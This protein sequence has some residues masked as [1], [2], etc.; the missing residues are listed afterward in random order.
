MTALSQTYIKMEFTYDQSI[1][2][3]R[4]RLLQPRAIYRTELSFN[5]ITVQRSTAPHYT[6]VSYTW[7]TE[8]P[9]ETIQLNGRKFYVRPNLWSCLHYIGQAARHEPWNYLWVDAICINQ[10]DTKERNEQVKL[11]D[12]TYSNAASV[13]VWLGLTPVPEGVVISEW[14]EKSSIKTLEVDGLFW[15]DYM[16]D[17]ANREYWGRYWI[18]QEFL[19]AKHLRIY[20]SDMAMDWQAFKDLVHPPWENRRLRTYWASPLVDGRHPN[21]HPEMSQPLSQLLGQHRKSQCKD[22]RDRVFALLGLIPRNDRDFLGRVFPD[23]SLSED[24]VRLIT[25][26][27][28][29][30]F[31][32]MFHHELGVVTADWVPMFRALG[33][34][35]RVDSERLLRLAGELDYLADINP[36][37]VAELLAIDAEKDLPAGRNETGLDPEVV[38]FFDGLNSKDLSDQ[39]RLKLLDKLF[40]QSEEERGLDRGDRSWVRWVGPVTGVVVGWYFWS[41]RA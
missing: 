20:C 12:Q 36:G 2:S 10:G 28:V 6:A 4:L 5:L 25:V 18:I 1:P 7:G 39:E 23:Y 31:D 3:S 41:K 11:M 33:V 13:S 38:R 17:L 24:V 26:A 8:L 22:P 9:S 35:E 14:A 15:G 16:H 29:T 27:H 32:S 19:L 21:G 30:Q 40:M 34:E 37:E